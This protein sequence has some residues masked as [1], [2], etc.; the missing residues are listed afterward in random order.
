MRTK[1]ARDSLA[2]RRTDTN[3]TLS[4][5]NDR[6]K[7]N[8]PLMS[9]GQA[10]LGRYILDHLQEVA[11]M[12]AADLAVQAGVSEPTVIRFARALG[13][14][15]YQDLRKEVQRFLR[16]YLGP[17]DKIRGF[18]TLTQDHKAILDKVFDIQETLLRETRSLLSHEA[19]WCAVEAICKARCVFLFGQGAGVILPEML[20]FRLQRCGY[21]TYTITS[22]GRDIFEKLHLI[23]EKDAVVAF[24][25]FQTDE[26]AVIV[27]DHARSAGAKT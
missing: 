17:G 26:D 4:T 14:S 3:A 5:I 2:A 10:S 27:L 22:G 6:I 18:L 15:G 12:S 11:F 1:I 23:T 16:L 13:Y 7:S 21:H 19:F 24:T 20:N 8:L 9:D 25:F